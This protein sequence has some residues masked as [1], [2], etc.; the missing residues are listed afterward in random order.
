MDALENCEGAGAPATLKT[1]SPPA[2]RED[3]GAETGPLPRTPPAD[4]PVEA[5]Q[6]EPLGH[7]RPRFIGT[8]NDVP[9]MQCDYASD[10]NRG[11]VQP[12]RAF[13]EHFDTFLESNEMK[14]GRNSA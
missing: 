5:T 11:R 10:G 4:A 6:S 8:T 13:N 2:R 3:I 12:G 1:T 14:K 7:G 9:E